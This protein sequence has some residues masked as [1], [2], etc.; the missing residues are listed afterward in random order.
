MKVT[1]TKRRKKRRKCAYC[2]RFGDPGQ[3]VLT[4]MGRT[5]RSEA[6]FAHKACYDLTFRIKGRYV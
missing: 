6:H 5:Y 2:G 4:P 1:E 3:M